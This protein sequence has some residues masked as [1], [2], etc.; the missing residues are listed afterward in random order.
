MRPIFN[1]PVSSPAATPR[2]RSKPLLPLRGVCSLVD[3]DENKVLE[4]L[5]SGEIG[6]TFDVSLAQKPGRRR[7]LRVLP[8]A[9]ADYLKAR[10]CQLSWED[11]LGL[12]LPDAP[13][14]FASEIARTLNVSSDHIYNLLARKQI[15]ACPTRRRGPGGSARVP[16]KSFIQFLQ[17]RRFP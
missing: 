11:V 9:V 16:T 10:A 4:L 13:T 14:I 5:E 6:W 17:Q 15:I 8:A 1:H 7:H 3:K 12:M 2:Q